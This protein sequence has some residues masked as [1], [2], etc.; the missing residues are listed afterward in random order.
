ME[1]LPLL[2]DAELQQPLL[3]ALGVSRLVRSRDLRPLSVLSPLH[4]AAIP[5]VAHGDG[6]ISAAPRPKG[7]LGRG[8]A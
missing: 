8:E 7:L 1:S 2:W 5:H 6:H 4:V 3:D